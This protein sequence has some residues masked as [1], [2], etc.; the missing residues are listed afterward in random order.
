MKA[1]RLLAFML[2]YHK[3]LEKQRDLRD[4]FLLLT[5]TQL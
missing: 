3:N 1:F 5:F 2:I 4:C